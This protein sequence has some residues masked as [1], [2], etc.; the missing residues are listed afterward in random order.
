MERKLIEVA[1]ELTHK[2]N[3]RCKHCYN[4][5]NLKKAK[6][7][8]NTEQVF[9]ALKK[10]KDF[11]VEKV[12][13]GGGE[14]LLR[15]DFFE[16]WDFASN[17]GFDGGFSTN[18]LLIQKN[19]QNLEKHKI[20][21]IQIS[22][23]NI[24]NK[25]DDFR[26]YSG[27]FEIVEKSIKELNKNNVKINIATT[28]TAYNHNDLQN[29]FG[30][31]IENKISKWKIMKYIPQ[32]NS[33]ELMLSKEN[34]K[35]AVFSLLTYGEKIEVPEIIVA[36]EFDLIQKEKDYNDMQCFGGKSFLSLKPDGSITPC[37]YID[38]IIC[39]NIFEEKIEK[40]WNSEKMI[41]FAKDCF[42]AS[43]KYSKN[44]K[45]GCKAVMYK[46]ENKIQCDGYCWIKK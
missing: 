22:L 27:L 9:S 5:E 40:I 25:H 44:C 17:L 2:C 34:Y 10:L 15:D 32:N 26:N 46:L 11:G 37:S 4:S 39:G 41:D 38:N 20:D 43:C 24:K 1:F 19:M 16:I 45:G 8:M 23:D 31:C 3:L 21:K 35:N 33:D 30:F 12:K 6:K 28:L 42:D 14:P 18:G 36:R 7:E 13:F 29:I